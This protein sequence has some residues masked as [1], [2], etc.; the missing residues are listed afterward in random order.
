MKFSRRDLT[1]SSLSVRFPRYC[2]W[3]LDKPSLIVVFRGEQLNG[4]MHKHR[5]SQHD[6]NAALRLGGIWNVAEVHL[7]CIETNGAFTIYRET[8]YPQDFVST[9]LRGALSSSG[10]PS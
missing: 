7:M 8:D 9:R 2:G 10:N 4:V 6:L 1:S 5:I 3:I